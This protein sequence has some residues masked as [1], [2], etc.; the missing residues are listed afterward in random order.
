MTFNRLH[1]EP[2]DRLN[3]RTRDWALPAG[4]L[5]RR[6]AWAFCVACSI[7]FVLCAGMLNRL[8]L[9][10]SPLALVILFGYSTAKR[11]T[12]WSHLLLGLALGMAPVGAWIGIR[13]RLDVTPLVLAA[14]VLCWVAG[15]DAIYSCQDARFDRRHGLYSLPSRMGMG[16]ALAIAALW[17]AA[18]LLL[19]LV[20]GWLGGLGIGY[21]VALALAAALLAWEQSIV[22]PR[23]LARVNAAFFTA[24]GWVSVLLF[25]GGLIDALRG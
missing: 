11:W 24:N 18:A 14:A 23:N 3:P 15:F 8:A 16:R 17:H 12:Q 20:V 5:S 1:D 22:S 21:A 9:E 4:L 19:F 25:L 13:G 7:G 2:Y 6:F 10:L